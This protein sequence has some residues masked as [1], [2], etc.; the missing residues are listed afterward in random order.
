MQMQKK[1]IVMAGGG[2]GGHVFPIK[3]LI[4]Y[5]QEHPDLAQQVQAI[6]RF[7][8]KNSLEEENCIELQKKQKNL[9]FIPIVSGKFRREKSFKSL[10]LNVRDLFIFLWGVL[11]SMFKLWQ[12]K[13]DILFCKG[14]YVALPVVIAA[15]IL[16]KPILVHESDVLPGLVNRIANKFAKHRFTGFDGVFE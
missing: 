14:G 13:A 2:T 10:L 7:G 9:F 1:T 15:K 12:I 4:L 16:G 5:Q 8:T 11:V 6:Y 3:S